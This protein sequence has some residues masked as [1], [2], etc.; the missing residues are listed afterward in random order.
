MIFLFQIFCRLYN[1]FCVWL[2]TEVLFW[3]S[4]SRDPSPE[5]VLDYAASLCSGEY[6]RPHP[7][8]TNDKMY[9]EQKKE[10]YSY[11]IQ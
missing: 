7:E 11:F 8:F 3:K 10:V 9:T 2:N 5:R 6:S 4:W 1:L